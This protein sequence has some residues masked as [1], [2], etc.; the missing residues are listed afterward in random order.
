MS[1]SMTSTNQKLLILAAALLVF[2]AFSYQHSVKRAERF[3]RGQKF[4]PNLNPD[5]IARIEIEKGDD[6]TVLRRSAD[7]ESF[8]IPSLDGYRAK[9][10]PVNRLIKD[11]LEISLEKEIGSSESLQQEL[12]LVAGEGRDP[13]T[14]EVALFDAGGNDMVRFL[15]GSAMETGG[16]YLRRVDGDRSEIYLTDTRVFL[17]SDGDTYVE[18]DI[19]DVSPDEVAS[20]RGLDFSFE[21]PEGGGDLAL[22]ELGAGKK[23]SAQARQVKTVLQGLR[24]MGHHLADAPEVQGLRFDRQLEVVLEDGSGYLLES[25]QKGEQ[26]YL[27]ISGFHTSEQVASGRIMMQPDA[28]QEEMEETSELMARVDEL[29][30]FN[31]FHGSWTYEVTVNT[32]DRVRAVKGDLVEDA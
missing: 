10:N 22:A 23:E 7:G 25:A 9:N 29:Q 1:Q 31:V 30:Q 24:F 12:K 13:E 15:L 18:K 28:S 4:L 32:A 19:L 21:R 17:T 26:H 6:K 20:V 3:E 5:E 2:S 16:T 8:E 14:V 27:R 11:V